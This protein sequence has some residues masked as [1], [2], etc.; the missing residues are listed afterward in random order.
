MSCFIQATNCS[1]NE[2]E[3]VRLTLK[4]IY[5]INLEQIRHQQV[6]ISLKYEKNYNKNSAG[7]KYK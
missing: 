7:I 5:N 4:I 6:R 1:I 3:R 2:C